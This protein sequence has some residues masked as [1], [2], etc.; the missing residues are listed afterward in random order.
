MTRERFRR[1]T[2]VL[3]VA[4]TV[5][6]FAATASASDISC[7]EKYENCLAAVDRMYLTCVENA[8]GFWSGLACATMKDINLILCRIESIG[9]CA[10]PI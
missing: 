3:L 10:I 4:I 5:I 8:D 7:V 9:S 6:G 2:I 1:L